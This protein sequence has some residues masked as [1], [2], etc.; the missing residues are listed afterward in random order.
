LIEAGA[1]P[2]ARDI[3]NQIPYQLPSVT[4]V[5]SQRFLSTAYNRSPS[6][7]SRP[8]EAAVSC[9]I[10]FGFTVFWSAGASAEALCIHQ[11]PAFITFKKKAPT[12]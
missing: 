6:P 10:Q 9:A 4:S 8:L 11:F 3:R 1:D 2:F 12:L 5:T 7:Y